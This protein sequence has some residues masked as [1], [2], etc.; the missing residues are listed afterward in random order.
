MAHRF[1]Q[2]LHCCH[3]LLQQAIASPQHGRGYPPWRRPSSTAAP[4]A[5]RG[6]LARLIVA[7]GRLWLAS[8]SARRVTPG[9]TAS[10][11]LSA[12]V[13]E[14]VPHASRVGQHAVPGHP[15]GCVVGA[16]WLGVFDVAK[17]A[18]GRSAG[19]STGSCS[20]P[21]M[22]TKERGKTGQSGTLRRQLRQACRRQTQQAELEPAA[23]ARWSSRLAPAGRRQQR[24]RRRGASPL[25]ALIARR[26]AS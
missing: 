14:Q 18:L 23:M 6:R 16:V 5:V 3:H 22:A 11:S 19:H 15:Q 2:L 24:R 1:C 10:L 8:G 17:V 21:P 9:R 7:G 12:S 26:R 20:L 13:V 4:W 25:H